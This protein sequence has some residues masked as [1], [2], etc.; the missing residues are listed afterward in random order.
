M[1]HVLSLATRFGAETAMPA[2]R[3]PCGQSRGACWRHR[4][5]YAQFVDDPVEKEPL[6]S[7]CLRVDSW[8]AAREYLLKV[9]KIKRR[10]PDRPR[11]SS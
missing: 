1:V 6:G 11:L 10:A 8:V 9:T 7:A 2:A 5:A 4:S 3:R